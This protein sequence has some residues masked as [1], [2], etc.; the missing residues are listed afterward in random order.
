MG[1]DQIV[2]DDSY[3]SLN[4]GFENLLNNNSVIQVLE[5]ENLRLKG[6][7]LDA[8]AKGIGQ[9]KTITCLNLIGSLMVNIYIYIY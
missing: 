1:E 4:S 6:R 2:F 3:D 8:I 5:L 9:N 7:T